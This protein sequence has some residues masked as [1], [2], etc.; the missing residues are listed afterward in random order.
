MNGTVLTAPYALSG[1]AIQCKLW[2]K[3]LSSLQ[4]KITNFL[5]DF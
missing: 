2:E 4:W 3:A 1:A 5:K